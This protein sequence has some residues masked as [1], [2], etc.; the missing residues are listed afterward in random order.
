MQILKLVSGINQ[1]FKR[2]FRL[3][4][5]GVVP[6]RACRHMLLQ[7]QEIDQNVMIILSQ[8]LQEKF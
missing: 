5:G 8:W 2:Y 6:L 4:D 1:E 3:W 7:M